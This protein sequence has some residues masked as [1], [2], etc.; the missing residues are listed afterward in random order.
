MDL[1]IT[2]FS[3][4]I[5]LA[6]AE[7]QIWGFTVNRHAWWMKN[8]PT[9]DKRRINYKSLFYASAF[10]SLLSLIML[11]AWMYTIVLGTSACNASIFLVTLF[12]IVG[13]GSSSV[14]ISYLSLISRLCRLNKYYYPPLSSWLCKKIQKVIG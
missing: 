13:F 1:L 11:F 5:V 14:L 12:F 9:Q 2:I 7:V 3:V 8:H 6:V 4:L 10:T